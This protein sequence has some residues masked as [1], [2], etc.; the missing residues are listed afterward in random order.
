MPAFASGHGAPAWAGVILSVWAA[1]SAVGGLLYGSRA[2]RTPLGSVYVRLALVLPLG[3][4]PALLA[5][6]VATMALL[7]IP[8][9]LLIAPLGAAGNQLVS[10]L[11]PPGAVTEAYAWPVTALILGF[12]VGTSLGGTIV[13]TLDWRACFLAASLRGAA[14]RR[15]GRGAPRD[16]AHRRHAGVSAASTDVALSVPETRTRGSRYGSL[17]AVAAPGSS[18][19]APR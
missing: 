1:A 14:R 16:A 15:A 2:W 12:S 18:L 5:G 19:V 3:F 13:E 11:A 6:S 8:A 10:D 4:L 7:I 9:G 17:R